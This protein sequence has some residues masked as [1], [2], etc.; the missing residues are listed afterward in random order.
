VKR[1]VSGVAGTSYD[2]GGTTFGLV[3]GVGLEL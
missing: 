2:V 1:S 3:G